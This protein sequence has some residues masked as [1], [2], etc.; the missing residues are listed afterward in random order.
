MDSAIFRVSG[1]LRITG[2]GVVILGAIESGTFH[3]GMRALGQRGFA[4]ATIAGIE[5]ADHLKSRTSTLALLIAAPRDLAALQEQFPIG[6]ILIGQQ[7]KE[8]C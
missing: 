7:P 3:R 5:F 8:E 4:P 1:H 2:R 6:S